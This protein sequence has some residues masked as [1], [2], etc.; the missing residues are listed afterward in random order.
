MALQPTVGL[1]L[2]DPR[3]PN[4]PITSFKKVNFLYNLMVL[5]YKVFAIKLA[6]PGIEP[7]FTL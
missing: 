4:R 7:G 3:P 2:L 5:K 6:S 1:S